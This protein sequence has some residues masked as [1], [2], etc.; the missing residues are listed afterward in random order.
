MNQDAIYDLEERV[1]ELEHLLEA[2]NQETTDLAEIASIIT[3]ILDIESIL[4][5]TMEISIRQLAGEVG[6]V[7]LLENGDLQEKISWGI[8]STIFKERPYREN[9]PLD[10]YCLKSHQTIVDND[11]TTPISDKCSIVSIIAAPIITHEEA[12]GVV[13][14][15]NKENE[16][17][18]TDRDRLALE[19]ICKFAAVAIDNSKLLKESLEKQKIEQE[20]GLAREVQTTFLPDKIRING[21]SI[22]A[23]YFPAR[24]VGGDY[25]DLIPI[26]N[27]KLFFLLGDVTNKGMPA[28]L[29]MTSVYSIVRAYITSGQPIN[30]RKIMVHLNDLLCND[31]IRGRDMFITLFMAYIDL[32]TGMMEYCNGGHPPAMYF[33][34]AKNEIIPL[35]RGG[36][37]VGQFAGL[38]Y[39][40]TRVKVSPG[41]RIFCYTDG[42]IEAEN[43]R[44]QLYGIKRLEE[45]FKAGLALSTERFSGV[46]KEEIDRYAQGASPDAIDDLTTLVIDLVGENDLFDTREFT[47]SSVLGNLERLYFDLGQ[48]LADTKL[49][50][51]TVNSIKVAVSEAFTNAI[52]HAHKRDRKKKVRVITKL[53]KKQFIADIQD[54]GAGFSGSQ[55]LNRDLGRN[56]M[57]E[58]GRGLAIINKL[59]DSVEINS[60]PDQGTSIKMVWNISS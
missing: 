52:I 31:I 22:A 1:F 3:S 44:G 14:I 60:L 4:A 7:M 54:H 25:Y 34:L 20:L 11:C 24:Q 12:I 28:A 49:D 47:Y 23:N 41:D 26:G 57:A 55:H 51:N 35:K 15:L 10:E 16:Q 17:S 50:V 29:V 43:R 33:R 13:I 42:V 32:S 53:N 30:V 2:K 59:A 21:L 40:A 45:F 56:P 37:L 18:F 9:L 46:I 19:L 38:Q 27:D 6:A 39:L 5:V 36:P 58:S 8:D 48:V